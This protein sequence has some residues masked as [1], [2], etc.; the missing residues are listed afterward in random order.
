MPGS[1]CYSAVRWAM[2][3]GNLLRKKERPGLTDAHSHPKRS[4]ILAF[5][6]EIWFDYLWFVE[7]R[8]NSS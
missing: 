7:S 1:K 5:L 6:T 2:R 8:C 4:C 3:D